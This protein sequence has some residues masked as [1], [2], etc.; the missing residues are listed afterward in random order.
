MRWAVFAGYINLC[1]CVVLAGKKK[2]FV[3]A[4]MPFF[5]L[6][7]LQFF[8][9]F[10]GCFSQLVMARMSNALGSVDNKANLAFATFYLHSGVSLALQMSLKSQN[11][12]P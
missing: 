5:L 3:C 7:F 11:L 12:L 10:K 6:L 8:N 4:I 2:Y 9:Q 1:V